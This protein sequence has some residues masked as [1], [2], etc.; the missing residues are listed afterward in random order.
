MYPRISELIK[1]YWGAGLSI[2]SARINTPFGELNGS[3][4]GA[5]VCAGV[6]FSPLK[7]INLGLNT[8]YSNGDADLGYEST[9]NA[10]GT[11]V[12]LVVGTYF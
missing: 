1:P 9:I 6:L 5:W 4:H 12:D 10:G 11:S 3:G 7:G 8:R 2:F